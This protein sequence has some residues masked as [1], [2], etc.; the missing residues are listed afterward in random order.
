[1]SKKKQKKEPTFKVGGYDDYYPV[2]LNG[3]PMEREDCDEFF[4]D[5]YE[6]AGIG[7]MVLHGSVGIYMSDGVYLLPNGEMVDEDDLD[8]GEWY[9]DTPEDDEVE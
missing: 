2:L 3:V 6:G 9:F 8:E 1:M 7:R 5:M 4:I